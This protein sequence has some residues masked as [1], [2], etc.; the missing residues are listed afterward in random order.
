MPKFLMEDVR[1]YANKR[2]D[3]KPN[4]S[5]IPLAKTSLTRA[6]NIGIK[7][8]AVKHCSIHYLRHAHA[9]FLIENGYS[10]LLIS[11]ILGHEKI[12]TTLGTYSHLYPN[13]QR[14]VA[15]KIQELHQKKG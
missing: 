15:E 14:E 13:K 12:E 10:P 8:S 4:E 6:M 7:R 1:A 2:Y 3:Y 11:E 5:L 9:S